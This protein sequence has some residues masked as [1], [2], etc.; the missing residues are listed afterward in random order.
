ME[1]KEIEEMLAKAEPISPKILQEAKEHWNRI[2][3]PLYSLG[4]LETII[5][6]MAAIQGNSN[7]VL[8]KKAALVIMCADHGVVAEGVTQTGYEVTKVVTDNFVNKRASAA[9]MAR[10]A[11]VD[12][13]PVDMGINCVPYSEN[14]IKKGA[15]LNRKIARGSGNIAK[16]PAMS[17]QQ[18][19]QALLTGIILAGQIK[20]M[21]YHMIATGEMGI[22]NT[23]PSSAIASFLLKQ[24]PEKMT[25]KGAG[26]SKEGIERKQKA[27]EA[28]IERYKRQQITGSAIEILANLGGYDIAG[29]AG[30][31]LGGYIYKI[32]VLI[33]GFISAVSA[34]C[35][36]EI[37][38]QAKSCMFATHISKEPAGGLVLDALELEPLVH[39]DM[40]L[41][42]GTG[43]LT[44]IP[45]IR[46][47]AQVYNQMGVFGEIAIEQ[48]EDYS[49]Q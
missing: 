49:E 40:C 31:F 28:A 44:V 21:G 37:C 26:L 42:E 5:S 10:E 45:M 25:G 4:K 13:F 46:M 47:A 15:V 27:V 3:K 29:I 19:R 33:D 38:P 7:Q 39:A 23:T 24:P 16:E 22:G 6:R 9:I 36:A 11:G 1:E 48:Y 35:A 17:E 41:G 18:C 43:A 34:L 32:P 30:Q 12:L 2:A 20:D 14:Q 8:A